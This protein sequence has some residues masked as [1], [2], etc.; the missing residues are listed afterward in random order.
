[1]AVVFI[2]QANSNTQ[3]I[4]SWA[5]VICLAFAAFVFNTSEFLPVGLLPDIASHLGETVSFTGLIIT[6]YAWVVAIVSLPL[7][8]LTARVERRKLLLF[9]IFFFACA[10]IVVYWVNTFTSLLAARV[11]VA[12][13]HA[14]FWAIM[15]PLAARM[16]PR[17]KYA[18]GLAAV[19]GGSIV[20]TVLGVPIGT[21]LGQMT[22]WQETF[23][24]IGIIAFVLMLCIAKFLPQ[25]PATTAGS[26]KSLPMLLKRPALVQL[27]FVTVITVLGHFTAYSFISPILQKVG[28][29]DPSA[30]VIFLFVFGISGIVGTVITTRFVDQHISPVMIGALSLIACGIFSIYFARGSYVFTTA[31]L[32]FWGAAMTSVML[33][34]HSLLIRIAP[35][36]TD[37]ATSIYSGIFNVGI[38]GGAFLGSILSERFG[39]AYLSL[40]GCSLVVLTASL[41]I[42]FYVK[43]GCAIY[44]F[45]T[46]K[47]R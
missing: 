25:C 33:A 31:V 18:V 46:T 44:G 42:F 3:E 5:P 2:M 37:I 20:A 15:T 16:A 43:T 30:V 12:L 8:A 4:T 24:L 7:T 29:F 40:V 1:M 10:H 47:S 36:A 21:K 14:I 27:Y 9:L 26:L 32:F 23:V 13:T 28:G 41:C 19:M 6:G 38:G 11:V 17:G 45:K 34:F 35:D 39:F 22:S